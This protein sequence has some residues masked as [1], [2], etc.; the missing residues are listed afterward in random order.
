MKFKSIVAAVVLSALSLPALAGWYAEPAEA[1]VYSMQEADA[2]GW[3]GGVSVGLDGGFMI[4][5]Y[6][7]GWTQWSNVE[8]GQGSAVIRVN[9]QAVKF[10]VNKVQDG[11]IYLWAATYRGQQYIKQQLINKSRVT[12]I[13]QDGSRFTLNANGFTKAWAS[14]TANQGI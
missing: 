1:R 2:Q 10:K 4:G 7:P 14:M 6:P 9:G 3:S 11:A 8:V 12:F 13:N 5:S